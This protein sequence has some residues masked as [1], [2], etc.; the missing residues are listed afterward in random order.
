MSEIVFWMRRD[1]RLQ[2]NRGLFEAIKTGLPIKLIFIFDENILNG[3]NKDDHRV[4]FI[5]NHLVE[6][7]RQLQKYQTQIILYYGTPEKIWTHILDSNP[8]VTQV[9][10]NQ[11]YESYAIKR[12]QQ[13]SDL[14]KM[15]GVKFIGFKDHVIFEPNEVLKNDN[16]PYEVYTPFKNKWLLQLNPNLIQKFEINLDKV[17]FAVLK[18][19]SE[20]AV[21]SL[22]DIGFSPS[23]WP[24]PKTYE[25]AETLS[26]YGLTR[27]FPFKSEGTS[28]LGVHLRVGTIST[29]ECVRRAK[30]SQAEVWLSELIWREFFIHILY[31]FP[32]NAKKCFKSNY[33]GILWRYD[34]DEFNKW[35]SGNTGYPLVDAGMRELNQTGHM[36]NRIRMVTASFLTK[37]LLF[38]WSHGAEYFSK[39]LFD[40]EL[41]SNNGL[42]KG[43]WP[44]NIN[45]VA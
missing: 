32:E 45:R 20:F 1:L 15:R 2:D 10:Y 41:A 23:L 19:V 18:N 35:A 5:W 26:Q 25:G 13:I 11:D 31:F 38:H 22:S 24:E 14:A 36:H 44:I 29:R 28:H 40:F 43:A 34:Q 16:S 39:K 4:T 21:Q 17:K 42:L 9:F 33:E 37:H 7:N 8:Q 3:L 12:D 30:K 6:L 27:D